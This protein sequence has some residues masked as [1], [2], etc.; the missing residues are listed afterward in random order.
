MKMLFPEYN[1][2]YELFSQ[3]NPQSLGEKILNFP[4]IRILVAVIWVFLPLAAIQ[5]LGARFIPDN[6]NF[7]GE[8]IVEA[9]ISVLSFLAMIGMYRLYTRY[10][11]QRPALEVSAR[12]ALGEAVWGMLWGA[13]IMCAV[14]G[15]MYI[16]GTYRVLG[17]NSPTILWSACSFFWVAAF[18]EEMILRVIAFKIFEEWGGS[19][20][21]IIFSALLFGFLPAN[22]NATLST[23]L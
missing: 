13:G 7:K 11:E 15:L 8:D 22:D 1:Q 12:N 14:V 20:A 9:I 5:W 23:V 18:A 3:R 16:L 10:I 19:T 17:F 2:S 4:L 21:A 6:F